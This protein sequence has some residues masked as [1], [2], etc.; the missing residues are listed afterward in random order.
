MLEA[1][2]SYF[3]EAEKKPCIETGLF[4]KTNCLFWIYYFEYQHDHRV[5]GRRLLVDISVASLNAFEMNIN[6]AIWRQTVN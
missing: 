3:I 2:Q 1:P 6:T 4:L 5:T